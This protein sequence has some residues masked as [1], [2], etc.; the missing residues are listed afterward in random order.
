MGRGKRLCRPTLCNTITNRGNPWHS[1]TT[2]KAQI[3]TLLVGKLKPPARLLQAL[4]L[5]LARWGHP[6]T[7]GLV[8]LA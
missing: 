1:G 2:F 4:Y 5:V 3:N 7:W 8:S 6:T